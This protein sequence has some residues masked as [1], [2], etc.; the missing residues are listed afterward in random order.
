MLERKM[1]EGFAWFSG[2]HTHC[3]CVIERPISTL[4][5]EIVRRTRLCFRGTVSRRVARTRDSFK[6]LSLLLIERDSFICGDWRP[7]ETFA[8]SQ[9]VLFPAADRS[10]LNPLESL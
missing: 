7:S 10:G 9:G 5:L 1:R 6:I 2:T 4:G 3:E 8:F